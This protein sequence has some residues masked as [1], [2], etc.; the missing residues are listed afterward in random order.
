MLQSYQC[1][2]PLETASFLTIV[3]DTKYSND[4][5]SIFVC[6]VEAS[7]CVGTYDMYDHVVCA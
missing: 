3:L 7:E 2:V 5:S 6:I 4:Y 1:T